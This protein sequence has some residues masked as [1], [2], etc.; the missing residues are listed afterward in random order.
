MDPRYNN[1]PPQG[2]AA[3][4]YP[5]PAQQNG[6]APNGYA[7]QYPPYPQQPMAQ[8]FSQS[9]PQSVQG[10]PRDVVPPPRLSQPERPN[11]DSASVQQRQAQPQVVIPPRTP[12]AMPHMQNPHPRIRQGQVPLQRPVQRGSGGGGAPQ[13]DSM[14]GQPRPA[15]NIQNSNTN[16]SLNMNTQAQNGTP[17]Q[18]QQSQSF[19]ENQPRP[20]QRPQKMPVPN[21]HQHQHHQNR[22]PLQPQLTPKHR[23]PS[24]LHSPAS[25]HRSP[26]LP[27][28]S[29]Q[30]RSHPQVV[31][32]KA[33]QQNLHTPTKAQHAHT[34]KALP[35]DL[36]L[37]L[38]AT[39]DEYINA[40]RG[41]GSRA[42]MSQQA[43]DVRQYHKLMATGL[44]CMDA[45]L[46]RY[47]QTPRDEAKL[48]LRYAS[49]LVEE[50]ENSVM[51]EDVMTKG[52]AL[53][54]R[55]RLVDL[56]YA[57]LHLQARYQFKSNHRAALKSLD[58]P[59]QETETFQH[60]VW[61]YAFRFLKV[62]LTL[63]I[64]GRP[65]ISSAL[66]QLHAIAAHAK[67]RGDHA[68]F[69]TCSALEAM[70]HLRTSGAE[71]LEHAQRAI[72]A[73]RS[74]QLQTS[75]KQ[76]GQIAV[77]IDSVD[78]ACGIQ[79]G[80][81]ND[82]KMLA[83][84]E[85][86]DTDRG[87]EDGVFSVLIE[88]STGGGLTS[89]TGGV[90]RKSQDG[91]DELVFSWLPKA[92]LK[93]L[94]YYLS[95]MTCLP[96][97][98]GASYLQE[99]FKLTQHCLQRP[100]T[101]RVSIPQYLNQRN[102]MKALN[103]HVTFALGILA[104]F[105][106]DIPTGS[107]FL[108]TLQRQKGQFPFHGNESFAR[109]LSY[110]SGI[111]DQAAG[112]T[113]LALR[114]YSSPLFNLPDAGAHLD[115]KTDI[116]ILAAMNRLLILRDP[117]HPSH[118]LTQ[119]L[120]AQLAPLCTEHPNQYIA[121]AF[122]IMRAIINS[123]NTINRQKT[124]IHGALTKAQAT[125]NNQFMTLCLCYMASR[126]FQDQV[127][128]QPIKSARAARSVSRQGRSSLWQAVAYGLCVNTFR[129]NGLEEDARACGLALEEL[130]PRLLPVSGGGGAA[131]CVVG[132]TDG[133]VDMMG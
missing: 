126:F 29:S 66:Q 105:K 3:G 63:Q 112:S 7:M 59:I 40:A 123:D 36:R 9:Q 22:A 1:W 47:N 96:E 60:I 80:Q 11:Y 104:C 119:V 91:K 37:L 38:L 70:I 106:E 92:D 130:R 102:W 32:K 83:L 4:Q 76:L 41:L 43:A 13:R 94:A 68:I 61:V 34:A 52:I 100:S 127:G 54:N 72:A 44:A 81:A 132:K 48:R 97:D 53:C 24:Q 42:A 16:R 28:S 95:G 120:F 30:P 78:V 55:S 20:Q 121:A 82:K 84:Q 113:D 5:P 10:H 98:K 25:Q 90:F 109:Q 79:Q 8:Q 131:A 117:T 14:H 62:S 45:V 58:Q 57:M 2:Y 103:W 115:L 33:S 85:K 23:T 27:H 87:P 35:A 67:S 125:K 77:L 107:Q 108:Q 39:A 93:T 75:V 111:L 12:N 118:Y 124:L 49:L 99:G 101:Y 17:K 122:G 6:Y 46:K 50:T 133:D 69:V 51:I 56:R 88:K 26:S 129:R 74:L 64:P 18:G 128:A 116:S 114:A 86:V 73:A 71:H 15:A 21:Q 31:I 65:E 19:Q 89:A 110:L